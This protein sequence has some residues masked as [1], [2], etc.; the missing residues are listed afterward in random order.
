MYRPPI[1][2]N[3]GI[4]NVDS[5]FSSMKIKLKLDKEETPFS[6]AEE[7]KTEIVSSVKRIRSQSIVVAK[8]FSNDLQIENM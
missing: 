1:K 4:S 3:V 2:V 5:E 7:L 8:Q 6:L